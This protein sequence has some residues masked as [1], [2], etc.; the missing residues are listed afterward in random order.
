M[1]RYD[2]AWFAAAL[3]AIQPLVLIKGPRSQLLW[4]NRA[5][6]DYYGL[7]NDELAQAASASERNVDTAHSDPDDTLQY[8][9]D[10]HQV[11]TT[12]DPIQVI[13]PAVTSDGQVRYL[14]TQK[15]ALRSSAGEIVGTIGISQ[16]LEGP[17]TVASQEREKRHADIAGLQTLVDNL[18]VAVAMVDVHQCLISCSRLWRD[19]FPGPHE[20]GVLLNTP[21]KLS[22][23]SL[24]ERAIAEGAPQQNT[25]VVGATPGTF[26]D[27]HVHPWQL[28]DG[29]LGGVIVLAIDVT[30]VRR[31]E[32]EL[33]SLNEEL[34][35]LTYRA[36]HDLVAP[37]RT[38]LGWV[39]M[40]REDLENE[41]RSAALEGVD[42][43]E[44]GLVKLSERVREL[45]DLALADVSEEAPVEVSLRSM[46]AA[47]FDSIEHAGDVELRNDVPEPIRLRVPAKRLGA[48]LRRLVDNG[49]RFASRDVKARWVCLQTSDDG[50]IRV[51]DNGIGMPAENVNVFGLFVRGVGGYGGHGLGLHVAT[52]HMRAMGG[53]LSIDRAA[54]H[55]TVVARLPKGV[56]I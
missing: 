34:A 12:G 24:T 41:D 33:R 19:T 51:V 15:T 28:I 11:F 45:S 7:D 6:R 31:R 27:L 14:D 25:D 8:V 21:K 9:R 37:L 35:Q 26:F 10:D 13:E 52:K 43:A 4:A 23:D 32:R 53:Q 46:V 38:S 30:A 3:D 1:E 17:Q 54:K 50:A 47:L 40:I 29:R 16:V 42:R 39:R 20:R 56:W 5:M 49:I 2:A 18:P 22:L 48:V 36:S 44:A 55:T